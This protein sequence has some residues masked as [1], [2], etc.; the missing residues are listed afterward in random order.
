MYI[1]FHFAVKPPLAQFF[2]RRPATAIGADDRIAVRDN[3]LPLN[4]WR[5]SRFTHL[6]APQDLVSTTPLPCQRIWHPQ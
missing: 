5:D 2:A 6:I 3:V 4:V 1:A